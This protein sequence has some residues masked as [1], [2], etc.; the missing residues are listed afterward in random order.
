MFHHLGIA[1]YDIS[2]IEDDQGRRYVTPDGTYPSITTI[3]GDGDKPWLQEWR[4]SLGKEAADV[5][6]ARAAARGTAVHD[7]A[8]KFLNNDKN[9]SDNH[10]I[11]HIKEFH[12]IRTQLL[13]VSNIHMQEAALWSQQLKVAGRVD[14]IGNFNGNLSIIDFKTSTGSKN[15]TMV[16]DY[17]IQVTAY[18]LMYE[19]LYDVVVEN[20]AI[21]MSVEKGLPMVWTGKIADHIPATV[22]RINTYHAKR[23]I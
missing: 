1:T 4:A 16:Q 9:F 12:K 2:T 15:T 17:F 7:M 10:G 23:S 3:L 20:Y 13:Q 6:M 22:R 21:I 5:E 11:D 14:C 19:E 8:E 18:A